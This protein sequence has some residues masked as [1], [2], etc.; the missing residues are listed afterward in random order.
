[1]GQ[2]ARLYGLAKVRKAETR[3][4]KISTFLNLDLDYPILTLTLNLDLDS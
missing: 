2:S 3:I 1:M 4:V